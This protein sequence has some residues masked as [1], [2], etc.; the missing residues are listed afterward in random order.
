MHLHHAGAARGDADR[1]PTGVTRFGLNRRPMVVFCDSVVVGIGEGRTLVLVRGWTVMMVRMI[2][3]D[4]F[5][6]VLRGRHGR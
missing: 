6:H 4:V 1:V 3:A 2:V 5:V